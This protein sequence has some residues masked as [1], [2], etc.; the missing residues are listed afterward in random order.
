MS[1]SGGE[2]ISER[3]RA[4]RLGMIARRDALEDGAR[5]RASR[6]AARRALE[7][8]GLREANSVA[9]FVAL[10][11]EIDTAPLI[12]RLIEERGGAIVPRMIARGRVD[13]GVPVVEE[14]EMRR[15]RSFPGGFSPGAFGILEPDPTVHA[16]VVPPEHVQFV[17]VPG[18]VFGARDG[19]RVGYGRG[20]FDRYLARAKEAVSIG[21]GYDFQTLDEELPEEPHDVRLRALVTERRTIL[22][23]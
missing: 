16:E 2:S 22:F 5:A 10:G 13:D 21:Y 23:G 19:R 17:F 6:E 3:K 18:T 7:F 8:P 15:V 12:R 14:I 11:G 4:L 9:V 20:H 1:E